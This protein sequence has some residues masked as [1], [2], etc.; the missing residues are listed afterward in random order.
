MGKRV[1]PRADATLIRRSS[2]D[3][4]ALYIRR[5][6]FDREL[7][8][9]DRVPQDDVART[10]G[11]S[12]IP[13]REALIA[14][15]REGWVTIELH[16]GA[17]INAIDVQA[18]R[19]HYELYGLVYGFAARRAFGRSDPQL[20]ERLTTIKDRITASDDPVE[21]GQLS[22]DFHASVVDAAHSPRIKV[23]LRA[24]PALIP[25]AFFSEV[26]DAIDTQ[27]RGTSAIL[28]AASRGDVTRAADEYLRVMRRIGDKVVQVFRDR[29]LFDSSDA[30]A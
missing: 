22:I 27:R 16:R 26:P 1:L 8:P 25:G 9:G 15:E 18:V 2:A 5:L 24:M 20:I 6:I 14:L 13:V 7:R 19:D 30:A 11:I 12:R 3:Q 28:R 10:L 29:G 4:A 21:I 17:F 23:V